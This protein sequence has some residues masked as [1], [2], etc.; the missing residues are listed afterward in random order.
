M[1]TKFGSFQKNSLGF[2]FSG[3][4]GG[5]KLSSAPASL[6]LTPMIDMM[7]IML[8]FLIK[9]YSVDPAFLTPT[10]DITLAETTSEMA[11][12]DKAVLMIG[13]DGIMIEGKLIVAFKNGEIS[14]TDLMGGEI[15]ELRKALE[16]VANKTKFIAAKN[17][18][19]QFTGTLI[20]QAD[21]ELAFEAMKPILRTAGLA[22]FHDFKFAGVYAE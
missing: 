21:R 13:K 6:N 17:S 22:G 14:K 4:S 8:V 3:G 5:A 16:A 11:A 2:G 12:P 9:S 7:T 18:T 10:Q 20:L 1:S 15:P 19:V